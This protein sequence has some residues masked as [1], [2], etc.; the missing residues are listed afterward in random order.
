MAIFYRPHAVPSSWLLNVL[1]GAGTQQPPRSA[2]RS[3]LFQ[4]SQQ[5]QTHMVGLSGENIPTAWSRAPTQSGTTRCDWAAPRL[6]MP[7][8]EA[9]PAVE[10][11]GL[12]ASE[13]PCFLCLLFFNFLETGFHDTARF[14]GWPQT[15]YEAKDDLE[16]WILLP[17]PLKCWDYKPEPL[18]LVCAMWGLEPRALC[19]PGE[20]STDQASSPNL[21][22]L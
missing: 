18:C 22:A 5:R 17:P 8:T 21:I 13:T 16:L 2:S 20:P 1:N 11:L 3:Q 9:T 12:R 6:Q 19:T 14:P 15:C 10:Q 4:L 7:P